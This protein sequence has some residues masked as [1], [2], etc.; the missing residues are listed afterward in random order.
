MADRIDGAARTPRI[1][2]ARCLY[3]VGK[4]LVAARSSAQTNCDLSD[5][6]SRPNL[7]ASEPNTVT[8]T[9]TESRIEGAFHCSNG[10]FAANIIR[11]ERLNG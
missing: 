10:Y 8:S 11:K 6:S 5:N 9:D 3:E 2:R 4:P 7:S 1:C